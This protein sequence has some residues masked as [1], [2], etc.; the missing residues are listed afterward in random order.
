MSG[1][2]RFSR[3]CS[4]SIKPLATST[5]SFHSPF[6]ALGSHHSETPSIASTVYEKQVDFNPEP[7]DTHGGTK[8]YVVSEPDP[9]NAPYKVPAGAY[10]TSLPYV[11]FTATEAPNQD[12][13]MSSTSSNF[14]HPVLTRAAPEG[15]L[16]DRNPPPI[17]SEVVE[18]FSKL[19]VKDAWKA[20][21]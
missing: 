10:P 20:R 7:T 11:N 16:A 13:Q 17:D 6:A 4:K 18:K 12:G 3:V 8:T 9:T 21:K 15:S 2:L 19:G 14:A 1:I 5:R